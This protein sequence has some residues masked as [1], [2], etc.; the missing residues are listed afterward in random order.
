MQAWAMLAGAVLA[1]AATQAAGEPEAGLGYEIEL[2]GHRALARTRAAAEL[3][4]FTTDGCSGG[5]SSV[6]ALVAQT[7]PGFRLLH[8]AVPPWESC[9]VTHDRAYHSAGPDADPVASFTARFAA[10]DA[11]RVCVTHT[12]QSRG[13]ELAEAY[14][15]SEDEVVTGYRVISEAMFSAVR[16]GGAPCSGLSWRWGYG[17]PSCIVTPRD[18]AA[19]DEAD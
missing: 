19:G 4:P 10:D 16:A 1:L 6:W 8:G 13:A 5:M 3:A 17:Y 18:F 11:L 12:A 2:A 7:F 15:M 14:G 9:C